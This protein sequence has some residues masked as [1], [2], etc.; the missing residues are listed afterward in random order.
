MLVTE[1]DFDSTIIAG[2]NELIRA[3]CTDSRIEALPIREGADL[4]WDADEVNR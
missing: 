4:G 2:S 1:G 3:I